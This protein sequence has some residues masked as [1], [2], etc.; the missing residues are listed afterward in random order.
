MRIIV[1]LKPVPDPKDWNRLSLDPRKK[2]LIRT[3]IGSVINPLDKH[4]LEEALRLREQSGGTVAIV[5]M[6]PPESKSVIREAL[7][8]GADWAVLLS[9]RLFAGSDTLGTAWVLAS[10]IK[11][12]GEF[13]LILCGNETIDGG[14]AQVSAQIAELLDV[15]N[16]M[17]VCRIQP[18]DNQILHCQ[19]NAEYGLNEV[20]IA[21][22]V[23]LSVVKEINQPRYVTMMD[24]LDSENKEIAIWSSKELR[25]EENY[26]GLKNSLTQ[27][28]DL[29]IPQRKHNIEMMNGDAEEIAIK[30]VKRLD[31]LGFCTEKEV[32]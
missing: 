6:G 15:P 28:A 17:Y 1:C 22:P 30:L 32:K 7:A 27:M 4:A 25:I 19:A 5:S 3:G 9:D 11:A 29:Y 14:T 20:E 8:M 31:S 10:A 18:R 16:L 12:L 2:T 13:D 26:V 24:I 23:V 21:T